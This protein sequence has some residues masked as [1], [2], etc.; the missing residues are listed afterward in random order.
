MCSVTKISSGFSWLRLILFL[1]LLFL[2]G[3]FSPCYPS[4][5]L[6]RMLDLLSSLP[7][8]PVHSPSYGVMQYCHLLITLNGTPC[9]FRY[10]RMRLQLSRSQNC[11]L[12]IIYKYSRKRIWV[13]CIVIWRVREK[14]ETCWI[15]H[16]QSLTKFCM[17]VKAMLCAKVWVCKSVS[18]QMPIKYHVNVYNESI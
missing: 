9:L 10:C 11:H 13:I 15:K 18:L 7:P 14:C 6:K 16:I 5:S 2:R 1:I 4:V 12:Y 17:Y 8:L 3:F